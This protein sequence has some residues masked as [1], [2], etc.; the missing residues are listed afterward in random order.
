MKDKIAPKDTKVEVKLEPLSLSFSLTPGEEKEIIINVQVKENP[1][2][3]SA[4]FYYRLIF[5]ISPSPPCTEEIAKDFKV[6]IC[7]TSRKIDGAVKFINNNGK[8][9]ALKGIRVLLFLNYEPKFGLYEY[10]KKQEGN[11]PNVHN[12]F[13]K[14]LQATKYYLETYTDNEGK[15]EFI[16]LDLDCKNDYTIALIFETKE[17]KITYGNCTNLF[18]AKVNIKNEDKPC[19][20]IT[21]TRDIIIGKDTD[22]TF[23]KD[24]IDAGYD[25][26]AV[27]QT[28]CHMDEAFSVFRDEKCGD[29][30]TI[31][32]SMLPLNVCI[33]SSEE[34]TFYRRGANRKINIDVSDSAINSNDKPRNREWHEF[35]HFLQDSLYG[36]PSISAGDRNH[37]GLANS[38]SIDSFL[39]GFAEVTSLFILRQMKAKGTCCSDFSAD[40]NGIYGLGGGQTDLENGKFKS[41]TASFGYFDAGGIFH[42]VDRKDV[43]CVGGKLKDTHGNDVIM[44]NSNEEFSVAGLLLDLLDG[45]SW[46][47]EMKNNVIIHGKD[48]DGFTFSNWRDLFCLMKDKNIKTIKELYDALR[49]KFK[50]DETRK[51][52][53]NIF[54]DHGFFQDKN[55]DGV[56]DAQEKVGVTHRCETTYY[57]PDENPTP[58]PKY[59]W[60]SQNLPKIEEREDFPT[61]P[62]ANILVNLL[63]ETGNTRNDGIL[64]VEVIS[65]D[66]RVNFSYEREA[67]THEPFYIYIV[68]NGEEILRIYMKNSNEKPLIVTEEE[69]WTSVINNNPYVK[70]HTFK[71]VEEESLPEISLEKETLD[72]G[73]LIEGESR[74]ITTSF[75]NSGRGTLSVSFNSNNFWIS[76]E[77]KSF[78]GMLVLSTST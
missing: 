27:A 66:G 51:K 61:I 74:N 35:G 72:F 5:K 20:K 13:N 21:N 30:D 2:K 59:I 3:M 6:T 56:R 55:F 54:I 53:D 50:D 58:P 68:P 37:F 8:E 57:Y 9:C 42:N 16:F 67:K 48:D 34:G 52:I 78:E 22:I 10:F 31:D 62:Q 24:F 26:R 33:Y 70:E 41:D 28:F 32:K 69:L 39:E 4:Y 43:R 25:P 29:K 23:P 64:I 15:Y 71:M 38:N 45:G 60:V 12:S 76:V 18:F 7:P 46:Y 77:P 11:F 63:D 40:K 36:I 1:L 73:S 49:D 65:F 47:D 14:E 19:P 17:F 75:L 44:H